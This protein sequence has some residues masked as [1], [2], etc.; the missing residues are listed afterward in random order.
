MINKIFVVY[1]R[2]EGIAGIEGCWYKSS[3]VVTLTM[4]IINQLPKI[5]NLRELIIRST[6]SY[7]PAKEKCNV[8]VAFRNSKRRCIDEVS[9]L[10]R[11]KQ[12]GVET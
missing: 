3:W 2:A 4:F 7:S 9:S 6:V 8:A 5:A 12:K 11:Q 1:L 10:G